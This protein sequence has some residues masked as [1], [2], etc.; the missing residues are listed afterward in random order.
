MGLL[1][2][3]LVMTLGLTLCLTHSAW[4]QVS[5]WMLEYPQNHLEWNTLESEHFLVHYQDG[6]VEGA[7]EGFAQETSE[8]KAVQEE[9][10]RELC[11]EQGYVEET[12]QEIIKIANSVYEPITGLYGHEPDTKVSIILKDRVDYSNGAAYFFDNTIDIWLPSLDTPLRGT[13]EWYKN[14]IT[15]E[16]THIVQI[17]TMMTRRR[18]VPVVYLQWLAYEDE[19]RPDVLYGFPRH[20]VTVPFASVGIPAWMAEGTAQFMTDSV[21]YDQWDTHR[22]MLFRTR[23]LGGTSLGFEEMGTFTSKSSIE[24][25]A[26]YN[27]GF[28]FTTYLAD[29]FGQDV[30][31]KISREAAS[32]GKT[33]ISVVMERVTG[34]SG[35]ALFEAFMKEK[36]SH[37]TQWFSSIEQGR[38]A[39]VDTL[40]VEGFYNMM[41]RFIPGTDSPGTDSLVWLS[42]GDRDYARTQLMVASLDELTQQQTPTPL[43]VT[44]EEGWMSQAFGHYSA[45]GLLQEPLVDY[46]TG[47]FSFSPTGDRIVYTKARKPNAQ[48]ELY[49]DL[50]MFELDSREE[51]QLTSDARLSDPSWHPTQPWVVAIQNQPGRQQ[52]VMISLED[53]TV[54]V[55]LT[56]S[57]LSTTYSSPRWSL[58]GQTLWVA[59]GKEHG[60]QIVEINLNW[61]QKQGSVDKRGPKA[62]P[63]VEQSRVLLNRE[64]VDFR[65]MVPD[66]DPTS[67]WL[68]V[69][70]D[71]EGLFGLYRLHR[72]TMRMEEVALHRGGLFM[73]SLSDSTILMS[74]FTAQGYKLA[75]MDRP[76]SEEVLPVVDSWDPQTTREPLD[77]LD[78]RDPTDSKDDISTTSPQTVP[79]KPYEQTTHGWSYYPM[80]R[81][82]GYTQQNGTT[83]SRLWALDGR[84]AVDNLWRDIKIGTY[85]ASR[86]VL[87]QTTLFGGLAI[88]PGSTDAGSISDG[89]SPSNLLAMDRDLFFSMEFRGLPFIKKRWSPTVTAEL[90]NVVRNVK[91]GLSIEEFPCTSCLPQ[92]TNADIRYS[93]W[94]ASLTFRSK[95]NRYSFLESGIAYSPY[96][97]TSDGFVS[98]ELKQ[99]IP[100]QSSEY[101]RG[102][103]MFAGGVVELLEPNR[104]NDIAM[105][106]I[107]ARVRYAYQP[108]KLLENYDIEDGAL[109]PNY[110]V[111]KNHSLE[112]KSYL[113]HRWTDV[114]GNRPLYTLLKTRGFAYFNNPTDSFYHDYIGGYSGIRSYPFFALG[115][116]QSATLQASVSTPLLTG[117][118]KQIGPVTLDKVF[119]KASYEAGKVWNSTSVADESLKHGVEVELRTALNHYYLF[120]LKFFV[121]GAYGLNRFNVNLSEDF[122]TPDG[123]RSVEYGQEWLFY[124]GFTF[125]FDPL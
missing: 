50:W 71:H 62:F 113:G 85:V 38:W 123:I 9:K 103:S 72:E 5:P 77:P 20:V 42:N 43:A 67:P 114:L 122:V 46:L 2:G 29:R 80:V 93:A 17:Q 59:K 35:K 91:G 98:K 41:P 95:L 33:D 55:P 1:G 96:R 76:T 26:V 106:G 82:D 89:L 107:K 47:G 90:F 74:A 28:A 66:S 8:D 94:E 53:P 23:L 83:A 13:H 63:Y 18:S 36:E 24:R 99:F 73:P 84:A 112:L 110:A 109:S 81:V 31:E 124:L 121:S 21:N 51:S 58:D 7:T 108:S 32:G 12:A 48:G 6:C 56:N 105:Q 118:H 125:D 54:V 14:V 97:V 75:R 88:G 100:E 27:Q 115:G 120:P 69:I 15:H 52:L 119:L 45:H 60:R 10:D 37:Y 25:E 3:S 40:D 102:V 70:A 65:D 34:Y 68:Y 117:I 57:P 79:S 4:A 92:T 64:G 116:M 86:D 16:F 87:G 19:R 78:P 61:E 101:F 111:S 104:H 39:D 49:N 11:P 30:L 44:Q 22:D